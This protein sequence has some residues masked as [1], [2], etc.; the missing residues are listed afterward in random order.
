MTF[1]SDATVQQ[2]LALLERIFQTLWGM[3]LLFNTVCGLT[4]RD[5]ARRCL[6]R[7]GHSKECSL[8]VCNKHPFTPAAFKRRVASHCDG[9]LAGLPIACPHLADLFADYQ[10]KAMHKAVKALHD[11]PPSKS[12]KPAASSDD[13]D[14]DLL[15]DQLEKAETRSKTLQDKL[16]A[17]GR[18]HH[19]PKDP[20]NSD[21]ERPPAPKKNDKTKSSSQPASTDADASA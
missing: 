17:A 14:I 19:G 10:K 5:L 21:T 4:N 2:S 18:K 13:D 15:R 1:Y 6:F 16:V 11:P 20:K 8:Y 12:A 3:H 9:V 7:L